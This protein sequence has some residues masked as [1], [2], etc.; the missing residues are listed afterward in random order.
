VEVHEVYE[1][2]VIKYNPQTGG[3][4][5]FTEYITHF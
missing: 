5:L 4:G 3:G 1:Y 2:L